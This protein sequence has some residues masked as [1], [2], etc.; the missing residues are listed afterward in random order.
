MTYFSNYGTY[1]EPFR[2]VSDGFQVARVA[3]GRSG[4]KLALIQGHNLRFG[5]R[6]AP[7]HNFKRK[8][9]VNLAICRIIESIR[10]VPP[11]FGCDSG[12][13]VLPVRSGCIFVRP[14]SVIYH[15]RSKTVI[16]SRNFYYFEHPLVFVIFGGLGWLDFF[17]LV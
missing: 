8:K 13:C 7:I 2:L 9:V 6:T 16:N 14:R 17:S 4:C 10:T 15:V 12:V 5:V 3:A 11:G 1:F